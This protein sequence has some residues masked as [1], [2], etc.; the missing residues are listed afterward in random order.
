[1]ENNKAI[2]ISVFEGVL[3][4]FFLTLAILIIYAVIAH[5]VQL[6]ENITSILII[7]ATLVSV[8]YGS[9]YSSNKTGRKGWLNGLLV[10]ILYFIILYLVAILSQSREPAIT[11]KDMARFGICLFV[12][13]LSGMLGINVS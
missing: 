5:F 1:M 8:V 7:V 10:A 6:S 11:M 13:L 4:G 9:I 3:R 12:G 2:Y